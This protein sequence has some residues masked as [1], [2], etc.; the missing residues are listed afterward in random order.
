MKIRI[1]TTKWFRIEETIPLHLTNRGHKILLCM[2][3]K[4]DLS[5][6]VVLYKHSVME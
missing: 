3:L 4:R 1:L 2:C 5:Q 6:V